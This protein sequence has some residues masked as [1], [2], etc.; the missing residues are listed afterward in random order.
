MGHGFHRAQHRS[1]ADTRADIPVTR[2]MKLL[3]T[4]CVQGSHTGYFQGRVCACNMLCS[5]EETPFLSLNKEFSICSTTL[6][7]AIPIFKKPS[8]VIMIQWKQRE[9]QYNCAQWAP[10]IKLLFSS[11]AFITLSASVVYMIIYYLLFR[12]EWVPY[13][14]NDF[15]RL[16]NKTW[17][18]VS[19]KYIKGALVF[20]HSIILLSLSTS[21]RRCFLKFICVKSIMEKNHY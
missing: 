17:I 7:Y 20:D 8:Q 2:K 13:E 18:N 16:I 12:R 5:R 21:R 9:C 1:W 10:N 11:M 4:M 15:N 19:V 3:S 6:L 14:M